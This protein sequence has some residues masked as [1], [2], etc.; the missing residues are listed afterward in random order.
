MPLVPSENST[1]SLAVRRRIRWGVTAFFIFILIIAFYIIHQYFYSSAK[2]GI[3]NMYL[4]FV[5]A[6]LIVWFLGVILFLIYLVL[7][8]D[9]LTNP[10]NP[11][12]NQTMSL[13]P[14]VFRV[15]LTLSLLFSVVLMEGYALINMDEYEK[16]QKIL[17]PL[18]TAFQLMI[19]FYFGTKMLGMVSGKDEEEVKPK[20]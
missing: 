19:A 9:P 14:G 17:D 4:T 8:Y 15:I 1:I 6:L 16:I 11:Y 10:D 13:P 12:I 7:K 20:G 18:L 3:S 5:L 2:P